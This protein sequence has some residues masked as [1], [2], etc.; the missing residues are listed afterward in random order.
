MVAVALETG[1]GAIGGGVGAAVTCGTGWEGD[2]T[3]K[4]GVVFAVGGEPVSGGA[5]GRG[6]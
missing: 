2:F 1:A 6:G 4:R 5:D 3:G